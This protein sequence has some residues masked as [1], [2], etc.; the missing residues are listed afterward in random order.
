MWHHPG[1]I[2]P[3]FVDL[4][5][6]AK[7]LSGDARYRRIATVIRKASLV[8]S[9]IADIAQAQSSLE[10][11]TQLIASPRKRG[12]IVR[13]ATENALLFQTVVLYARATATSGQSGERGSISIREKLDDGQ[14]A[15][16]SVLVDL[17]NRVV[18]HVYSDEAVAGDVWHKQALYLVETNQGWKTAS[19]VLRMQVSQATLDRLAR[20]L[21]VAHALLVARFYEHTNKITD[22]MNQHGVS[23]ATFDLC[24]FDAVAFY[25]SESEVR[26][27][28]ATM[29]K[30][31][32]AGLV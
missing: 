23:I 32:G 24:L 25:G 29:D 10:A 5:R 20:L 19:A 13:S 12:T 1:M 26:K 15:D 3:R 11:L 28:L 18:A 14:R 16:H 27:S 8:Q 7:E 6:L 30:G 31:H 2:L 9:C 22:L 17:R 21:P 4:E